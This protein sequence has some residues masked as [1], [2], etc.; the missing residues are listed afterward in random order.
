MGTASSAQKW[1]TA[2]EQGDAATAQ[3]ILA[4]NPDIMLTPT[5]DKAE[6]AMHLAA[7]GN[8]VS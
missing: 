3:A 1:S 7:R 8:V 2:V 5:T 6:T 4:Q